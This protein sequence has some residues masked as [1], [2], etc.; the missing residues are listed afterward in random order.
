MN[1]LNSDQ[2][3]IIFLVLGIIAYASG[4]PVG[5]IALVGFLICM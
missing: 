1:E 2:K 3:L 5:V 4:V